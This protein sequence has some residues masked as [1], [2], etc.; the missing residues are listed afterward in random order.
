MTEQVI[1]HRGGGR[2][3]DGH[4]SPG[5]D[6]PLTPLVVAPGGGSEF[7]ER[8][9]DGETVSYTLY[10]ALGTDIVNADQ[11]TVRGD[12]FGII[13]NDWEQSGRGIVEVLCTRGQG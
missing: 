1:R 9:R 6:E 10:F 4:W 2:D 11:L 13:V 8:G 5:S 3:E 7:T 12:R